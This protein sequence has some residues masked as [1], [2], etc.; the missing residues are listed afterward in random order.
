MLPENYFKKNGFIY[1]DSYKYAFDE[2]EHNI[3][4]FTDWDTAQRWL[5]TEQYDFR[6]RELI[7]LT[8]ARRRG[9]NF[10]YIPWGEEDE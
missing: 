3:Y 2:W 9:Y 7:S 5:H 8:E 1:G 10:C 6:E 4:R